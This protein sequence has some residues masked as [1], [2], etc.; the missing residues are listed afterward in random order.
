L[1]AEPA[2]NSIFHSSQQTNI[3]A[4]PFFL[5]D[6]SHVSIDVPE[7]LGIQYGDY[8]AAVEG[9]QLY[10]TPPVGTDE[11]VCELI[12][13]LARESGLP[14]SSTEAKDWTNFPQFGA[15]ELLDKLKNEHELHFGQLCLK[16]DAVYPIDSSKVIKLKSSQSLRKHLR[17][18]PYR[19]L[20][21][22]DD[23]P[24]DW[25]V[26]I[27]DPSHIPSV[28]ETVY[29]QALAD[30]ANHQQGKLEI[31]NLESLITRQVGD[32]RNL[33]LDEQR[34][35]ETIESVCG[36]CTHQPLWADSEGDKLPCPRACNF[37]LSQYQGNPS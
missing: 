25:L 15:R 19:P 30:W 7:A 2:I 13:D 6:G 14:F 31:E 21:Y 34:I 27:E 26:T 28:V 1:D 37:W 17:T 29:P 11:S 36:R 8:P 32:F 5:A 35:A 3:I 20:A 9:F 10:Y 22:S 12:L 24:T 4:V 18:N 16:F 23:L 33:I